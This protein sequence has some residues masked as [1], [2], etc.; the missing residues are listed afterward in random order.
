M[1]LKDLLNRLRRH[2]EQDN[3]E[4]FDDSAQ[5]VIVMNDLDMRCGL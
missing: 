3:A 2:K 5:V 4:D 1:S